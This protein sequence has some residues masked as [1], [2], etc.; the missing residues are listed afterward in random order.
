MISLCMITRDEKKH[1]S[2]CLNGVRD[3]VDEIIIVDTGS[4]DGTDAICRKFGAK[5]Y[6]YD[7]Q[8]DFAAAR[9][10]GIA[11]ATGDWILWLDAD[12]QLFIQDK[13]AFLVNISS[14]TATIL[15]LAMTH[16]YGDYPID[17]NRAY[18]S[19]AARLF[20]NGLGLSFS[21]RIHENLVLGEHLISSSPL[22][23]AYIQHYGY[24]NDAVTEKNKA[25]RNLS[26][27]L[28]NESESPCAWN[29][30]HIAAEYY[31]LE[32]FNQALNEVNTCILQFLAKAQM[33]PAICYKLKYDILIRTASLENAIEGL[34]L[35][36]TLYPD[37]VDLEFYRGVILLQNCRYQEAEASFRRCLDLGD[38]HS[39]YLT[40]AGVGSYFSLYYLG[41]CL[42][43]TGDKDGAY[44]LYNQALTLYPNFKEA[45]EKLK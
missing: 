44:T 21:G 16:Y 40:L 45:R 37:Y 28:L 1:I 22:P 24:M 4:V 33:P 30:Y 8:D 12:E 36:T 13:D 38:T 35:A 9:N 42:E 7:W 41:V 14:S 39:A 15:S 23:D 27:L 10:F 34:T 19:C 18:Y 17:E 43:N 31:R 2:S 29:H 3:I 20:K 32:K 5:V 26:L 25:M 6:H 11:K